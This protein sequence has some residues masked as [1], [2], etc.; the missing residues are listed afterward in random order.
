M[1]VKGTL[2]S[3]LNSKLKIG[4]YKVTFKSKINRNF[5]IETYKG[6]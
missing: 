3:E 4:I 6:L 2:K 1:N 5:K